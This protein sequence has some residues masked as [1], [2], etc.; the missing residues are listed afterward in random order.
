MLAFI[1]LLET[2]AHVFT[3]MEIENQVKG[4][5]EA[6]YKGYIAADGGHDKAES[7]F[8]KYVKRKQSENAVPRDQRDLEESH[9]TINPNM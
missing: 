1:L 4:Y 8:E 9:E 5:S 3:R 6:E 2:I 7:A